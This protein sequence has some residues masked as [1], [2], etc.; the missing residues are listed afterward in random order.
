MCLSLPHGAWERDET[1][2]TSPRAPR[3][4]A[5]G[6]SH[7]ERG[8]E[9]GDVPGPHTP[10]KK[11]ALPRLVPRRSVGAR[12]AA[13][14]VLTPRVRHEPPRVA[15]QDSVLQIPPHISYPKPEFIPS[16]SANVHQGGLL[17]HFFLHM[18]KTARCLQIQQQQKLPSSGRLQPQTK[19]EYHV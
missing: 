13:Y 18:Q 6:R 10:G 12:G 17:S 4:S 2:V 16:Q 1:G 7:A 14:L 19:E 8:S 9:K 15:Y 3:R 5:S 11:S